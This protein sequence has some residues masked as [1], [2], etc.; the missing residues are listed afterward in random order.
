MRPYTLL[1]NPIKK[2]R[3]PSLHIAGRGSLYLHLRILP[4]II[5]LV[6]EDLLEPPFALELDYFL[7][8]GLGSLGQHC[9]NALAEF[10][11]TVI[12]IEQ[13]APLS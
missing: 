2:A 3:S 8:C 11:V 4:I 9:V 13:I 1:I 12:G 10:Q 5:I 6:S 7:V